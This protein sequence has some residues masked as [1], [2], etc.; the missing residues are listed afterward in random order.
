MIPFVRKIAVKR[1]RRFPNLDFD[2]LMA[3]GM[4][5]VRG[6]LD[7]FDPQ[8]GASFSTYAHRAAQY[9]ILSASRRQ[10]KHEQLHERHADTRER[11]CEMERAEDAAIVHQAMTI[12]SP[13]DAKI[14]TMRICDGKGLQ[15]IGDRWNLSKERIRQ[16]ESKCLNQLRM[17]LTMV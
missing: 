12:L 7:T 9:K 6:A 3:A 4:D 13:R 1:A 8:A 11:P 16:I 5:G 14:L 10:R 2:D 15:T 17:H